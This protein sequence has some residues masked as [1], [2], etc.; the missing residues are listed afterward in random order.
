MAAAGDT[1]RSPH[2][3]PV[4]LGPRDRLG[5]PGEEG[6]R[7]QPRFLPT[8]T[9]KR[10]AREGAAASGRLSG[11]LLPESPGGSSRSADRAVHESFW[12]RGDDVW[13]SKSWHCSRR[14]QVRLRAA[15][16]A[17]AQLWASSGLLRVLAPPWQ[18]QAWDGT[19]TGRDS[20]GRTGTGSAFSYQDTLSATAH[21]GLWR[22]T[23]HSRAEVPREQGSAP[24]PTAK[25]QQRLPRCR[26][27]ESSP[28]LRAGVGQLSPR[29][30][31]ASWT[32][33]GRVCLLLQPGYLAQQPS[34]CEAESGSPP[35]LPRNLPADLRSR[36]GSHCPCGSPL[37][38][39]MLV[40]LLFPTG[41]FL[42]IPQ[43]EEACDG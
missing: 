33:Q 21:R 40:F 16:G 10:S 2:A 39:W 4:V 31:T 14:G 23:H 41:Y 9:L 28:F 29:W 6:T 20:R 12:L 22:N 8:W 7:L 35:L 30:E 11:R 25:H 37:G 43:M 15:G 3:S 36:R 26:R 42:L 38:I 19:D 17:E 5:G 32:L 24:P 13:E 34:T 18:A 1:G 27:T